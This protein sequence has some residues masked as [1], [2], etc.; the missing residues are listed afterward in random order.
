MISVWWLLL[1]VPVSGSV[2]MLFTAM[3]VASARA[4]GRPLRIVTPERAA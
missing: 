2:G 1:I 4:E 3:L